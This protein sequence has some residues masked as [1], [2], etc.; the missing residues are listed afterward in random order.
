MYEFLFGNWIG[1]MPGVI[2]ILCLVFLATGLAVLLAK[3][4]YQVR[5]VLL[6]LV[7]A[8]MMLMSMSSFVIFNRKSLTT[9]DIAVGIFTGI[10]AWVMFFTCLVAI[11]K[12]KKLKKE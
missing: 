4:E 3:N 6:W 12:L 9:D 1:F 5:K 7:I 10:C 11:R 8:V 2:V